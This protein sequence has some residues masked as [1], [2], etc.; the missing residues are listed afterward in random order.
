[1]GIIQINGPEPILQ[2][3]PLTALTQKDAD[4]SR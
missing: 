1:M 2:Y 3:T 4:W